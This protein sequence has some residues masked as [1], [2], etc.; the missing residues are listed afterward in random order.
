MQVFLVFR[1]HA[2]IAD[3]SLTFKFPFFFHGFDFDLKEVE[4]LRGVGHPE[5]ER[6]KVR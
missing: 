6:L 4:E 2:V 1:K 3:L 5:H